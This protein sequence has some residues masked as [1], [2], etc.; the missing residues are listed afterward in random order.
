[1][2]GGGKLYHSKPRSL[3]EGERGRA[4]AGTQSLRGWKEGAQRHSEGGG[5]GG[6][7]RYRNYSRD[8]PRLLGVDG[9]SGG[10]GCGWRRRK[11]DGHRCMSL[12]ESV[13]GPDDLLKKERSPESG[14]A[15]EKQIQ[16]RR[17]PCR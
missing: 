3:R 8:A 7:A 6:A 10:I 17:A 14:S 9:A 4:A 1:M 15:P 2:R 12:S 16:T 13:R 5:G 11:Q